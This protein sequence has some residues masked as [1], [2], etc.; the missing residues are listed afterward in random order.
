MTYVWQLKSWP[1]WRWNSEAL[2]LLIS[3]ARLT[4]TTTKPDKWDRYLSDVFLMTAEGEE[5]FLNNRLL[6]TG[7]ARFYEAV[8]LDD[9]EA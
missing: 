5:I 1:T 4:I 8:S 3:R 7:H 6:E 9:W 2:L